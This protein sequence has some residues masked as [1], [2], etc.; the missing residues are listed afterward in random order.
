MEKLSAE[1]VFPERTAVA[2][3]DIRHGFFGSVPESYWV[4]QHLV[5]AVDFCDNL[6]GWLAVKDWVE[7]AARLGLRRAWVCASRGREVSR[8]LQRTRSAGL[9]DAIRCADDVEAPP[10][11]PDLFLSVLELFGFSAGR[12]LVLTSQVAMAEA[13][14]RVGLFTVSLEETSRAAGGRL[15]EEKNH[16]LISF[17]DRVDAAYRRGKKT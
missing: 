15:E 17:L 16:S 12:T 9:W 7:E 4:L 2:P 11:A 13:A 6:Q 1:V 5:F 10:P 14:R 8:F 3:Q